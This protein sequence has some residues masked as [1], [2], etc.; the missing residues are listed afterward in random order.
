MSSL[1]F[2]SLSRHIGRG[3][4]FLDTSR[5]SRALSLHPDLGK[6]SAHPQPECVI[7]FGLQR[8]HLQETF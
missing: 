1:N 5:Q 6:Q 8:L 4:A 7:V 2:F 3:D